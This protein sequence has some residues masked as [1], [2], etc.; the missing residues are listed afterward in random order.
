MIG[1]MDRREGAR[2]I[3]QRVAARAGVELTPAACW[4][5]ARLSDPDCPGS[6]ALAAAFVVDQARLEQAE[7][8]L[9]KEQLIVASA[10][11]P[12]GFELSAAGHATLER[13]TE[14][15]EQRLSELLECWRP[16]EHEDL[17]RLIAALAR[18]FFVD[19]SA[20]DVRPAAARA[21]S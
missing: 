7:Q 17:A 5:L 4:M 2:E 20:L 16:Q 9:L 3:V 15:G 13:L 21:S 10:T 18:E 6:G 8:E 12:S 11:A 1:R 19:S 14:T